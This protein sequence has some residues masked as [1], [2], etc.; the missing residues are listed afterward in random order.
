MQTLH[1]V[2]CIECRT[3][4][5]AIRNDARYCSAACKQRAFNRR[6]KEAEARLQRIETM[7]RAGATRTELLAVLD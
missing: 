4:F 3:V 2:T 5:E 7:L 6:R 1:N